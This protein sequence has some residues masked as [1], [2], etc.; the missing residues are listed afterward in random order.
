MSFFG[1]FFGT[2]QQKDITQA[3]GQADKSLATGRDQALDQYG[4]A[5]AMYQPYAQ[6]GQ[7]ANRLYGD[8]TGANGQD[9]YKAAM[10]SYAGSD[11]FRDQNAQYANDALRR[12]YN[13]RGQG[14]GGNADLA[15]A[16]AQTERGAQDWGNYLNRLQGQGQMGFQATGAQAGLTQGMGDIQSGYGQQM[17]GNAINYGNA[18]AGTRNIGLQNIMN[19]AGT[20]AKFMAPT[21]GGGAGF[22]SSVNRLFG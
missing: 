6:Q 4:Q 21:P 18:M 16:R 20:A 15:V 22:G 19:V 14:M 10:S 1:S 13:A 3:K 9:A 5:R 11:P 17:A 7:Q 12:Q 8:A 2:D